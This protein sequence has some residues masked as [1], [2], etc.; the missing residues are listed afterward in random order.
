MVYHQGIVHTQF[1]FG[2]LTNSGYSEFVTK[3]LH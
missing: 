3:Q 2:I 1:K